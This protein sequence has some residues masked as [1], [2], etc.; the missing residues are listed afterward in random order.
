MHGVEDV[1]VIAAPDARRGQ[2]LRRVHHQPAAPE[3]AR[4]A[5]V[6][7]RRLAPHKVP[8]AI[9]FLPALPLTPRGKT[10][11]ARLL[12]AWRLERCRMTMS[13]VKRM[14]DIRASK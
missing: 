11:R 13:T 9:V 10:D 12:V 5:P 8:R 3:R 14:C 2:Q 1:R 7:R 4:G 6:L